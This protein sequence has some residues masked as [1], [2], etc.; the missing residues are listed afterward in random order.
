MEEQEIVLQFDRYSNLLKKVFDAAPAESLLSDLGD[1]IAICPAGLT[2]A[3]GGY[4]GAL[5]ERSLATAN[6]A[7]NLIQSME[8]GASVKSAVKVALVAELGRVGDVNPDKDLYIIQSSDWHREKLGQYFKYNEECSKSTVAHRSLYLIQYYGLSL[9]FEEW[10]SVFTY[11]GLHLDENK[12]YGN[13]KNDL[14]E[15]MQ[16]SKSMALK[17][18]QG[19]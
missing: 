5:V 1:R 19:E 12:F 6:F 16:L 3:D 8:L 13:K 4:H 7:K 11:G 15:V 9:T 18:K 14:M 17:P 2:L 10:L